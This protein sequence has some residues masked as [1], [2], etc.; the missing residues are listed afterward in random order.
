M[1]IFERKFATTV[2]EPRFTEY[3]MKF[4]VPD[5]SKLER[6]PWLKK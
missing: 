6:L 3:Q 1:K 2:Y 5:G 4:Q